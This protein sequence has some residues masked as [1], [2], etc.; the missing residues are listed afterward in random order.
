MSAASRSSAQMRPAGAGRRAGLSA[1]ALLL[2]GLAA[3]ACDSPVRV[4]GHVNDPE[5]V[6]AIQSGVHSEEDVLT[7]LGTPSTISTFDDRR[8][9]YIG[10]KSTKFAFQ[11][12]DIFERNVLVV[13]FDDRGL[14]DETVTYDLANSR[15]IAPVGRVTPTEGRDF[16]IMQQI[17]GN[18]GRLPGAGGQPVD[19]P[20]P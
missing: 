11:R 8:W 19:I 20:G 5:A 14:V 2:A 16:T 17:L 10:Q 12:P 1:V 6:A 3:G 4:H 18:I 15:E 13:S 7:L 9:Y